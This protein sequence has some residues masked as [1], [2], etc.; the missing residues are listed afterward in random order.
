MTIVFE[1]DFSVISLRRSVCSAL[2]ILHNIICGLHVILLKS[3]QNALWYNT[4][5]M[6]E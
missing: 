3:W 2:F 5:Y 4:E 1:T 6:D